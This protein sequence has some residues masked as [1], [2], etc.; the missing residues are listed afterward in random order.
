MVANDDEVSR[1]SIFN[2]KPP[3]IDEVNK[4]SSVE[5]KKEICC[6]NRFQLP[7]KSDI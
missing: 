5:V 4:K 7:K 2:F 3:I 6:L 1:G